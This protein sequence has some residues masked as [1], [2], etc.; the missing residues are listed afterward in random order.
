[1]DEGDLGNLTVRVTRIE[2]DV[3]HIRDALDPIPAMLQVSLER[4]AVVNERI[5]THLE[6]SRR[7]WVLL[8]SHEKALVELRERVKTLDALSDLVKRLLWT[9][10]IGLA[11]AVWWA[12]QKWIEHQNG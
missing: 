8:E 9:S 4:L 1:M 2:R 11:A 12:V 3:D 10:G 6:E 7:A 5:A